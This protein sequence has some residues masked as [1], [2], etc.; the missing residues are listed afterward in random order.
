MFDLNKAI[1]S[2][3][4]SLD[5]VAK[6]TLE[7]PKVSATLIRTRRKNDQQTVSSE[8]PVSMIILSIRFDFLTKVS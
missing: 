7:E 5:H 1:S 4:D 6:E 3:L 8:T 2:V